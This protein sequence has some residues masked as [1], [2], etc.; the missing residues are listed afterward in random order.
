[1]VNS[2][3]KLVFLFI[4]LLIIGASLFGFHYVKTASVSKT[5]YVLP[6]PSA[7]PTPEPVKDI[8][9]NSPDGKMKIVMRKTVA[10]AGNVSYSFFVSD[11]AGGNEK[12]IFT[13]ALTLKNTMSIS[14]NAWS[15]DDNYLFLRENDTAAFSVFVFKADGQNFS[16]GSAYI[17]LT[18]MYAK[19]GISYSLKDVTGWDSDTLL[20]VLTSGPSFWFEVP[21]SSFIQLVTK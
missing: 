21:S 18:D 5:T 13:K 1:V 6:V 4:A 19:K 17:D 11:V 3:K 16:D 7:T 15:P 10:Q 20:H 9:V 14:Q 2:F 8:Q 12:L